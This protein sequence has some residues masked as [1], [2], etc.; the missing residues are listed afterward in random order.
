MMW[1]AAVSSMRVARTGLGPE[2][3]SL[4]KKPSG[5]LSVEDGRREPGVRV[6][7]NA[8]ERPLYVF[9]RIP[10]SDGPTVGTARGVLGFSELGE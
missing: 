6:D 2:T 10:Q 1:G 3:Q 8:P 4:K 5:V 9:Q 7:L